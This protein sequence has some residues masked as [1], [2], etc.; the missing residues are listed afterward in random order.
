MKEIL[1]Q[2]RKIYRA[3]IIGNWTVSAVCVFLLALVG[4]F[5]KNPLRAI[6]ISTGLTLLSLF[7][8][9]EFIIEPLIFKHR[10]T[11]AG[12]ELLSSL[13]EKP[14]KFP[15]RFFF[16][17]T[18][19]FFANWKIKYADCR[20]ILSA[21]LIRSEIRLTLKDGKT[22]YMPFKAG[23]NP[24]VICAVLRNLNGDIDFVIDG[25]HID[26]ATNKSKRG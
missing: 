10:I 13:D 2:Y 1:T 6:I 11:K 4:G 15:T 7:Y 14:A 19:V 21:E 8:T 9:A 20:E 25:K 26:K 22:L 17:N 23:E 16:G 12:G 18:A 24:A 3:T 5:A